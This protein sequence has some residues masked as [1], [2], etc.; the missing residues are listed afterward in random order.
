VTQTHTWLRAEFQC[1]SF[2]YR[3]PD[4][5]AINSVNPS[6]PSPLTVQMAMLASLLREGRSGDAQT[7]LEHFPLEL[8]V[9]P[10][11]GAIIFR[12]FMRFVRPPKSPDDL[13]KNTGSGYKISPHYREF[14]LLEGALEVY[15]H[16]P[17]GQRALFTEALERIPYLGT[18][19]SLVTC[20]G[21]D[22]V[23]AP[24]Q[25]CAVRLAEYTPAE[26]DDL[27]MVQL[28]DF[29]TQEV[30]AKK[31]PLTLENVLPSQRDK[32][33]YRLDTYVLR[34]RLESQ[35]NV[36]LFKRGGA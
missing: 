9:R 29:D 17:L 6:L 23:E 14:A 25:N 15:V 3:M 35:G 24:P 22:E 36:K 5:V 7:L 20:V 32:K 13:D 12:A 34:G 26:D 30:K 21:V 28:A 18:K 27:M 16:T 31:A 8:R 33:H 2:H 4:T 11:Q 1:H 10:P 19:D